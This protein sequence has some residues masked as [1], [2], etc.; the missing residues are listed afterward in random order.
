M[1]ELVVPFNDLIPKQRYIVD[2][3]VTQNESLFVEGPPGSGKTCISMHIVRSLI[4]EEVVRPLV[5]IY[6]NSLLGY[7][8]SSFDQLGITDSVTINTKDKFYWGLKRQFKINVDNNADFDEKRRTILESLIKKNIDLSYSI[9]ILDEIQDFTKLEW[10]FLKTL[11]DRFILL[12]DF[13]QRVYASDLE[14]SLLQRTTKHR[15]LDKIFR[16]GEMIADLVQVFSRN[17]KDLKSLV[18]VTN[19]TAPSI[20]DCG[21]IDEE[22]KEIVEII[23]A[24]KNDGGRIAIISI[25]RDRL[26]QISNHLSK[27][28]VDHLHVA[29]NK[30][31]AN[32]DFSSNTPVLITSAS[33]KG[34]EFSTV[35]V[36][37]FDEGSRAV[38]GFRTYGGFEENIYVCLS[39]ATN[40][41][42]VLRNPNTV[43]EIQNL[44]GSEPDEDDNWWSNL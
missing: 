12:G 18:S 2:E 34:L 41:L 3:A 4:G 23:E 13:E 10:E 31:F 15:I 39:R 22:H 14:K 20:I 30:D 7:L 25:N 28:D 8:K 9:I 21:G 19:D 42:Y 44:E 26:S 5:L 24:R 16:F 38:Y 11:S 29:R 27:K 36:V 35:I 40:H 17:K 33:A 43:E 6:N 37:G 1:A 32:Y